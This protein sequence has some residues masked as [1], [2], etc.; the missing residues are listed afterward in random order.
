M[1]QD[2][3]VPRRINNAEGVL[4]QLMQSQ[5]PGVV[6]K[7]ANPSDIGVDYGL[8]F[9]G[10]VTGIA[11]APNFQCSNLI[12][13][14]DDFFKDYWSYVVRDAGG[15]GAAPQGEMLE[16]TGY[17]S[18]T[19]DFTVAAYTA[20]IAVGDKVLLIHPAIASLINTTYGLSALKTLIDAIE[21]KLDTPAT[22]KADVS[23]LETDTNP[24]VMGRT[25]IVVEAIDLDNTAIGTYH[26]L[27]GTTQ[28]VI[29][30]SLIFRCT[31]DLS[32]DAGFTGISLQT[33]DTTNQV[34]VSQA[35]GV[36]ANL[37]ADSQLA[38]TGAILL[39]VGQYIDFSVYGGA[40]AN[41]ESLCDIVVTYRAVVSGGYLA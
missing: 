41:L 27:I 2:N 10:T 14:G 20:A 15:A 36:K 11:G 7:W 24:K 37:T 35:D 25:Q 23:T 28:N 5:G 1:G 26:T 31:R 18:A 12:G 22:F 38:W 34:F 4:G 30:E 16:C 19:G 13:F 39:K 6:E 33:D 29:I 40:V 9:I 3:T 32:G 8:S 17:D 21:T